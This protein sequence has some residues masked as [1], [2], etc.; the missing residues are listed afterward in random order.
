MSGLLH[1]KHGLARL[2]E[3]ALKP[4]VEN[5]YSVREEAVPVLGSVCCGAVEVFAG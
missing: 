2:K 1:E 3:L 4:D 5:H